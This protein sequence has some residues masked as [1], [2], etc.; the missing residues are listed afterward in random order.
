MK[1]LWNRDQQGFFSVCITLQHAE[2]NPPISKAFVIQ[3]Q[4][5][6]RS[7][8]DDLLLFNLLA[9]TWRKIVHW[10]IFKKKNYIQNNNKKSSTFDNKNKQKTSIAKQTPNLWNVRNLQGLK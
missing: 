8:N 6:H 1:L 7:W 9:E 3:M 10:S 2:E 4:T 5:C